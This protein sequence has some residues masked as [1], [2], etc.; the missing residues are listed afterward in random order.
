MEGEKCTKFFFDLERRRGMAQ[1]IKGLKREN[2]DMVETNEE[3]LKAV[4]EYYEKL[5]KAEGINDLEKQK[6][7]KQ[8]KAKLGAEDKKKRSEQEIRKEEI[9]RAISELNKWKSPGIDGLGNEFYKTFKDFL[10]GILKEV[11]EEIFKK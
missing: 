1:T 8:I 11:Y 4:K 6:L 2:G 9:K 10:T 5:F 7:L 3:I